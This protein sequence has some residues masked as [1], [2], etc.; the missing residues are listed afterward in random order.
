MPEISK[1]L[2]CF[3]IW[4]LDHCDFEFWIT[5]KQ[6]QF[7][8]FLR[9]APTKAVLQHVAQQHH[10]WLVTEQGLQWL[11]EI[12]ELV[13][14]GW[15]KGTS[16][17]AHPSSV[18]PVCFEP[19]CKFSRSSPSEDVTMIDLTWPYPERYE[20]FPLLVAVW[21][22]DIEHVQRLLRDPNVIV[23]IND[24]PGSMDDRSPLYHAVRN[25]QIEIIKLLLN[26]RAN[27]HKQ[28]NWK[29]FLKSRPPMQTSPYLAAGW[30][31]KKVMDGM[32]WPDGP[33]LLPPRPP[34]AIQS[35]SG[36]S[37]KKPRVMPTFPKEKHVKEEDVQASAD[38]LEALRKFS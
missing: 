38:L 24:G 12:N 9:M 23:Q 15:Y 35:R 13:D 29:P 18:C 5:V 33:P 34:L 26:A 14:N 11:D 4:C 2:S 22:G 16:V 36:Q 30:R 1:N 3:P 27:P 7:V 28:I 6:F 37:M 21:N 25:E 32:L 8:F 20:S 17:L 19:Y 31:V 10:G